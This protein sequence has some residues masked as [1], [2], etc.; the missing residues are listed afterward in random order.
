MN[1]SSVRN[2]S[3]SIQEL[4][5]STF[6]IF[7]I[8]KTTIDDSFPNVQFKIAGYKS[9]RKDRDAFSGGL[10]PNKS[11]LIKYILECISF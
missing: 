3:V 9:F 8:S 10:T 6:D 7:F 5:K 4:I 2:K 1:I 11:S